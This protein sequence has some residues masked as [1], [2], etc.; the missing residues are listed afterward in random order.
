MNLKQI[1]LAAIIAAAPAAALA[2]TSL[3]AGKKATADGSVIIT[4]AADSHTLYG[5]LYHQPA[6]DHAPGSMRTVTEWDTGKRLGEIPEVAHT[7]RTLGN[8]N[9]HGLTIAESTWGGRDE[10]AGSGMIDYGSLIYITLQRARTAREAIKVMTDLVDKYG[11]ASSGESFSIADADEAWIMELIGKGKDDK[12]AVWVARR[13]PDDCISGHANHSRIHTFPLNDPETLYSP[14]VISFARSKG[15][16]NGKDRDF[17]FS[18]AYAVTDGGAL[19][20]CDGRVWAFY[21][22]HSHG[23]EPYLDWVLKGSGEPLPLWVKPSQPVGVRDMQAMMRDHFEDTPL[24]MTMDVGAGPYKVPYRWRPLTYE[25]DSVEYTHERAIATQQTGFSFVSQMNADRPQAMRGTLWFGVDDANTCVYVPV[26]NGNTAVP[27]EFAV[28]NGDLYNL[29]WESAF[30]V[31][32]YVANQAY[33]RYS[34]MIPDIRKVQTALEDSYEADMPGLIKSVAALSPAEASS[35]LDNYTASR[36]ADYTKRYKALG[37]YL[38]VKYLDGNVKR[39]KN[40]EFERTEDGMPVYP[41]FPGY[42]KRYYR[43]IATDPDGGERLKSL[44]IK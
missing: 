4:Y 26:F 34:Q 40:G 39:E 43:S 32:N 16:F 2:C 21:N 44:I 19:R 10:L 6:A 33:H 11:Y 24:D 28:G 17:S 23:A 22:K 1:T 27:H 42:D 41:E 31:N 13:V 20:G 3:I 9:E 25:V 15:Y 30:W 36:T 35:T 12:G 14:D 8:M 29:S 38:L 37:D 18:K 7:Y 5:E